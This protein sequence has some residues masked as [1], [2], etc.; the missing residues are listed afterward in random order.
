MIDQVITPRKS[1]YACS[2]LMVPQ[3]SKRVRQFNALLTSAFVVKPEP[4]ELRP[5]GT[6]KPTWS[7]R[8]PAKVLPPYLK[9]SI[10]MRAVAT[11]W[12]AEPALMAPVAYGV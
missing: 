9:P 4:A 2:G 5:D 8:R 7:G 1:G 10:S 11:S 6:P 3:L 12:S